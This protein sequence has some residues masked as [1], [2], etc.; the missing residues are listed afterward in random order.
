M[1]KARMMQ[2]CRVLLFLQDIPWSNISL[3]FAHNS[4]V[5]ESLWVFHPPMA[6]VKK[7]NHS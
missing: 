2:R 4:F 1:E 6:R 5:D 3:A 7:N